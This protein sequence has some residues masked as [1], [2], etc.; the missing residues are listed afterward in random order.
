VITCAPL[1]QVSAPTSARE[2][3]KNLIAPL[4]PLRT[5]QGPRRARDCVVGAGAGAAAA[6]QSAPLNLKVPVYILM[7]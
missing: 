7:W 1:D 6:P 5:D 2:P 4:Q 3:T